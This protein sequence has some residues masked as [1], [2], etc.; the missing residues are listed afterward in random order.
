MPDTIP[1]VPT[2]ATPVVLLLHTPDGVSL[3]R[4]VV[5]PTQTLRV[6]VIGPT[7]GNAFTVT[8]AFTV[9][10]QPKPLEIAYDMVEVPT[11]TPETIPEVPTVATDVLL[12]V[13][14][15]PD[16]VCDKVVVEDG[17]KVRVPVIA[18]A[19]GKGLT[20]TIDVTKLEQPEALGTV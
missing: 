19:R 12:L 18:A 17:A 8:I 2:V 20:V 16:V 9:V 7:V 11:A 10:T 4:A 13:H 15:P 3:E 6:P 1:D 5:A 14:V